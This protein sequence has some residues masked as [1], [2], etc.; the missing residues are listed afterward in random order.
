[1][2]RT[3]RKALLTRLEQ[4]RSSKIVS[5]VGSTRNG[6]SYDMAQL[7]I[8]QIYD[9]ISTIGHVNKIDLFLSSFGGDLTFA[10]RLVQLIRQFSVEFNVIVPMHAFS[11][12]TLTA[13]GADSIV[14]LPCAS[15]GPTDPQSNSFFN[16]KPINV[17]DISAFINLV[18]ENFDIKSE[19]GLVEALK[20]LS[21]SDTRIHPLALGAAD[22]GSKLARKYAKELL[23]THKKFKIK[24]DRIDKIVKTFS[25]ELFQH[26]HPINRA[27]VKQYGLKIIKES[28]TTEKL[29]WDLYLDYESEMKMSES[30][31]PIVEFKATNPTLPVTLVNALSPTQVTLPPVKY[32]IIES[33]SMTD[34]QIKELDVTGLKFLD[35]NGNL[36]EKYSWI[37]KS[38]KWERDV[39]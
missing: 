15:L 27:E 3:Q 9:H 6:A 11:A 24:K 2:A 7:D 26:N 13:F 17:E 20:I 22:R 8:R 4:A 28:A 35:G 5:Y 39:Q 25:S 30:Y 37:V 38:F 32:A 33:L 19:S 18:K 1:M 12:A 29:I 21:Q 10:W 16:D 23:G 31:D 14:M 36:N 34:T